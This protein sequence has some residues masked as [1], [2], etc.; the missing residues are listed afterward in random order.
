MSNIINLIDSA[1]DPKA[2]ALKLS[3]NNILDTENQYAE[4]DLIRFVDDDHLL[5]MMAGNV[6]ERA[7][8]PVNTTFMMLLGVFSSMAARKYQVH[9]PDGTPLPIGLYIVAEQPSGTGKTRC[10]K[11]VQAPFYEILDRVKAECQDRLSALESIEEPTEQ[12]AEELKQL[13]AKEKRLK[14]LLFVTNST[15]EALD[16]LLN[17]TRGFFSATSTEQGLLNSLLGLLY[18]KK[19]NNND[20]MLNGFDGGHCGTLRTSRQAYSGPIVGGVVCYAQAGSVEKV[21]DASNGTGLSER[22]LMLAEPHKLGTRDHTKSVP[23][24]TDLEKAY[25][26][27]C[28]FFESVLVR[29]EKF[30]DL[31]QLTISK[32]GFR[33]INEFRNSIE[34][35]LADGMKYSHI[36]LRGAA[37]KI[38]MQIMK[39]AANLHL[40]DSGA[41]Q[42]EDRHVQAAIGIAG[43]LLEANLKLCREKGLIGLKAEFQAVIEYLS[44]KH[45]ECSESEILN[46]LRNTQPFKSFTGNKRE[47]IRTALAEMMKQGL[48][49]LAVTNGKP[50]Y[51]LL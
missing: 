35:H 34:P 44:K 47:A 48:I 16:D 37:S 26:Q 9:Y 28:A 4:L 20:A 22:F 51:S 17:A 30:G 33:L 11:P 36:S 7:H 15:S 31:C 27:K 38:D 6:A 25:R 5:K 19:E 1:A 3:R 18:S 42:I 39:L 21:L 32:E 49:E 40:L 13:Q 50:A 14:A 41:P 12:E 29:P 43:S 46:S 23:P 24:D 8:M 2:E 10:F 45:G